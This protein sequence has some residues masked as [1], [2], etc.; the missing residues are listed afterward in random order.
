MSRVL[1][2]G[3]SGFIGSHIAQRLHAAG[4]DV[5]AMGR[6]TARLMPLTSAGLRTRSIDLIDGEL[7]S[8]LAGVD[9]VIHSAA[10]SSPWGRR[11]DFLAANVHATQRLLDAALAQ[12]VSR[13][14]HMSSPSIYFRLQDR[15]GIGEAFEPP[16]RWINAYAE[17]KWLA[18][19]RV[20]HAVTL[21]LPCVMLRPRAVFGEGDRAIF[22]R[23]L[24]LARRG[25]FPRVGNGQAMIDVT[26]VGNVVDAV[27][28]AMQP[29]APSQGQ[30]FNITNGEPMAAIDLLRLLFCATKS[31]VRLLPLPRSLA[32]TLGALSETMARALPGQPEPR[33]SRYGVGVLGFSQTLDITAAREQLGYRPRISIEQGVARFATWWKH[34]AAP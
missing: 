20:R 16:V 25:W 14:V 10:L 31:D 4:H 3:A 32:L 11:E 24:A 6:D 28:A 18:E 27:E 7:A 19:E 30:A 22:P 1:V 12:G 15:Y 26:Y 5:L 34:H 33:L 21:G 13:F 8:S 9:V 29:S 17:T 2:T 23:V